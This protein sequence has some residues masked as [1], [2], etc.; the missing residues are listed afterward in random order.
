MPH[1]QNVRPRHQTWFMEDTRQFN[2]AAAAA[3]AA[4][5]SGPA[6]ESGLTVKDMTASLAAL[7]PCPDA[8]ALIDQLRDL[9]DLK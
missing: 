6:A 4:A 7:G 5:G 3:F 8:A 9:E 1:R 2:A